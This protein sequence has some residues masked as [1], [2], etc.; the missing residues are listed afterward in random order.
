MKSFC[1]FFKKEALE[2]LRSGRLLILGIVFLIFGI[3]SPAIAKLTP[4]MLEMMSDSLADAGMVIGEVTVNALTSWAQFFKNIPIALVVFVLICSGA[5]TRE[6]ESDTLIL[7]LT[8]GLSRYKVVLAKT[9]IMLAMWTAGYWLCFGVTYGYTVYFW[10]NSIVNGLGAAA[11]FWWLFG[12]WIICLT[13]LFSTVSRSYTGVLLGA[14]GCYLAA[15]VAGLFPKIADY[16]PAK[17]MDSAALMTGAET[18]ED[19]FAAVF[20]VA[21]MSIVCIAAGIA[22]MNRKQM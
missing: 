21:A 1:A 5:F 7:V 18:A 4:L 16:T 2:S 9:L 13:V 20:I 10:D 22:A 6:Y 11:G 17:L 15:Y 3:M 19:Y 8:K 14:G 12:V